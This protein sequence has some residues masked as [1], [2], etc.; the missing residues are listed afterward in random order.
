[1]STGQ[2]GSGGGTQVDSAEQRL[3]L[4]EALAVFGSTRL[5]DVQVEDVLA[6]VA[7]VV[8]RA[9][10]GADSVSVTLVEAGR[11]YTRGQTDD[12]ADQL[13]AKQYELGDGP[14]LDAAVA[15]QVVHVP[16]MRTE[17][18]W[19]DY[20]PYCVERGVLSSLSVP[21]PVQREKVGALNVYSTRA[22]AFDEEALAHCEVLAAHAAVALANATSY[23]D[24]VR[25]AE[26]MQEAMRTRAVIEQAKGIV[27]AQRGCDAETA[28]SAL[29]HASQR[30][31]RKLREVAEELVAG[32][33]G[34]PSEM[35]S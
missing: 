19:P 29:R 33:C 5:S 9:V 34:E 8:R 32:V 15:T 20:S 1:M 23:H 17:T 11:A 4:S 14:C 7:D 16:D 18:R 24:A 13:D 6:A 26:Q 30:D 35:T 12:R 28:F 31:N 21:L 3:A 25:L 27:M 22:E 2:G 10:D